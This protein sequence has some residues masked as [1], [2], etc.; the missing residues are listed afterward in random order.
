M[1]GTIEHSWNGTIL[2]I[3]SDS[4]TSSMDLKGDKGDIGVRGPQG[5]PGIVVSSGEGGGSGEN[6]ATF[7]PDVST[8]G[9][10][11]WT[12]DK[13]L[14]NPAPVNIKG[15]QGEPGYTPVKGVD[16]FDGTNGKDG[17]SVT[18][19]KVT[20]STADGGSNVV[21]FSDGKTLTVKN[22]TKGSAGE[23][24]VLT[25]ADKE[26]IAA[27]IEIDCVK[28][29]QGAAN[30]GKILVVGT[31]G[32]F[33]LMDMPEGGATGDVIGTVDAS[34]N[35]LLTGALADG[36]YTL[37]YENADGTYTEVGT[38]EVGAIVTYTI[39]QNLTNVTSNNSMTSVIE[40]ERFTAT[41]TANDGYEISNV[42]IEMGG[43]DI[44]M[45]AYIG[46]TI[47]IVNVTGDIVIT[48]VAT[49]SYDNLLDDA[50]DANGNAF[51]GTNGEKG[52]KANTGL[53]VSQ[54]TEIARDGYYATGF[55]PVQHDK[56]IRIKNITLGSTADWNVIALYDSSKSRV[57]GTTFEHG[58]VTESNGVYE[59]TTNTM[60]SK[61]VAFI[62]FCCGSI[63]E[64]TIVTVNQPIS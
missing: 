18:V 53:T 56:P 52:Y 61:E 31:D 24:Y 19:S 4:G 34:N 29:N 40:G 37:K 51:V 17:T 28:T 11:S 13:G 6:G 16:Y 42:V 60:V 58:S 50:V 15:P 7:T 14:E 33:T 41:L 35:I 62:R 22:G 44:T 2:T 32:K 23:D 1:A 3:K 63:T 54:G 27:S 10:I 9:V 46:G 26:E 59:F 25:E 39:T 57:T 38:L 20:T 43:I 49:L 21:T 5:A 45:D 8:D 30:V 12:N 64:N 36:T 48:A 47:S 55:I